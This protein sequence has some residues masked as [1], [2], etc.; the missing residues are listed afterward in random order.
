MK[1]FM[2]SD[3]YLPDIG[4][5]EVHVFELQK[6]LRAQGIDLTLFVSNP[7]QAEEDAANPVLRE[8]WS[9]VRLPIVFWRMWTASRGADLYHAHYSYKLA[10][11][12]GVIAKLRRKPFLITQHGMG[13]L[14]QA[15]AKGIYQWL[16]RWYRWSSMKLSTFQIS[17]SEDLADFCLPFIPRTRLT[18]IPNGLDTRA[19][20]PTR[21]VP[22]PDV[23]FDG[24]SPL[25][26]TVRRLV[27]KNGIHYLVSALPFVKARYPNVQLAMIGDGRMRPD[28]E[29]RA[30]RLGVKEACL[31]LGTLPNRD[32]AP[33]AARADVVV[34]PS[35]AESTSIACAEMLALEKRVVASK[36]G[37]LIELLGRDEARGWLVSLV[38]WEACNYDAP[39]ELP[40]DR[41]R[42][43]ADRI[44]EALEDPEA[45]RKQAAA[46]A[47]AVAELDW[48]MITRKTMAVY[49]QLVPSSGLGN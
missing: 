27:P 12:L 32:V 23:R 49:R 48:D 13:L 19:F 31:F 44:I 37:G 21:V 11:V 26:L 15:G 18:V 10:M 1:V 6:R 46:R 33:I 29:A 22:S 40:E 30:A 5:A 20:D 38:P 43:L 45:P 41:Y 34:F 24:A 3:T 47:Y 17:T 35:T 4:G 7:T 36:V 39:E 2:T 25:L 8:R 9:L 16:H 42:A 14:D 28:I